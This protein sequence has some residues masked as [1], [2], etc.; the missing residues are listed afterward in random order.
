MPSIFGKQLI[1]G[2]GL[3]AAAVSDSVVDIFLGT[4]IDAQ[5]EVVS[6]RKFPLRV[7]TATPWAAGKYPSC[8]GPAGVKNW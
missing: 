4:Y 6:S 1:D 7:C 8:F 3:Q 2:V 5:T